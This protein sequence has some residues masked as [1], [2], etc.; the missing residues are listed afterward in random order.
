MPPTKAADPAKA[1]LRAMLA[2]GSDV[3]LVFAD[4]T[5]LP[6]HKVRSGSVEGGGG[7]GGAKKNIKGK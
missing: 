2:R 1:Q 6:A 3:E 5:R 7:G 4:G